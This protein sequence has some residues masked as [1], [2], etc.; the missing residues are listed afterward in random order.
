[1]RTRP[2]RSATGMISLAWAMRPSGAMH[3]HQAFIERDLAAFR[4]DHRLEGERDAPL[5]ERGDDLVGGARAVAAQRFALDIRP[6]GGE[7]AAALG[8]RGIAAHPARGSRI[9]GTVRAW[10]GAV[11][12]P[13][14]TVTATGPAVVCIVSSRTP[15][16]SRSAAIDNS[17][18]VQLVRITPNLLPEKR[19]R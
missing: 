4:L 11:T 6:V 9:S 13:M 1:M 14:V 2:S 16:S 3:A 7:R 12:P 18:G 15:A 5:V 19:P 10:R 8:A 17:S